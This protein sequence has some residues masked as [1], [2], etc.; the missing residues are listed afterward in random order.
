MYAFGHLLSLVGLISSLIRLEIFHPFRLP[1]ERRV[2][3][4]N[5]IVRKA[6]FRLRAVSS[7]SLRKLTLKARPRLSGRVLAISTTFSY[8]TFKTR[9]SYLVII[10]VDFI[11][12]DKLI[13]FLRFRFGVFFFFSFRRLVIRIVFDFD[14]VVFDGGIRLYVFVFIVQIFEDL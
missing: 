13:R 7:V 8:L 3:N 14:V 6:R 11:F 4:A 5:K 2:S 12:V 1:T 10:A 9:H